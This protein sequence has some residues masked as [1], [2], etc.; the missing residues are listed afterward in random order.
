[1]PH[2]HPCTDPKSIL[3]RALSDSRIPKHPLQ[4]APYLASR[5]DGHSLFL[6]SLSS[7]DTAWVAPTLTWVFLPLGHSL[8]SGSDRSV[9]PVIPNAPQG[10]VLGPL[11]FHL[12]S[13]NKFNLSQCCDACQTHKTFPSPTS[14]LQPL[15]LPPSTFF[16]SPNLSISDTCLQ[17]PRKGKAGER[18]RVLIS[19]NGKK[20]QDRSADQDHR[21]ARLQLHTRED[22]P[23]SS[24]N[25]QWT[26]SFWGNELPVPGSRERWFLHT[27]AGQTK[28]HPCSL[29]ILRLYLSAQKSEIQIYSSFLALGFV[30]CVFLGTKNESSSLQDAG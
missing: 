19:Y 7:L 30:V 26:G 27:R 12:P 15:P 25:Q 29:P 13:L 20:Y 22:F 16:L 28:Q 5:R 6:K 24:A 23:A 17:V 9:N 11:L 4:P 14:P 8:P 3:L 21:M 10:S 18:I 1:M 2:P